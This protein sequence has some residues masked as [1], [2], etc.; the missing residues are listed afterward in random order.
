M[1]PQT[2]TTSPP[3]VLVVGSSLVRHV[4]VRGGRTFCYPGACVKDIASSALQLLNQHSSAATVVLEAGLNDLK[5]Q[6]SELLKTD[7]IRLTDSLLDT[8]KNII[9]SGPLPPPRFGDVKFSRIRQ[10]HIWLKG[11]CMVKS[12]PFI[13][14]FAAFMNRPELFKRDV[15]H[16]NHAGSHL[17]STN[18]QLTL[19]SCNITTT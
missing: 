12:I 1:Q 2:P 5:H 10:L 16:P 9:I 13:D 6:W 15:I 4:A 18:I 8:G 7:F 14:N 17:L 3:S 19:H 11:Y